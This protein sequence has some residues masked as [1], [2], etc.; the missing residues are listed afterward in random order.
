MKA[1]KLED[2]VRS[3]AAEKE[4]KLF[5]SHEALIRE[6]TQEIQSG[7]LDS[8]GVIDKLK[9]HKDFRMRFDFGD[10]EEIRNAIR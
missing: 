4:M 1:Y 3:V 7:E 10:F 9:T 2:A 8:D 6:I 5:G